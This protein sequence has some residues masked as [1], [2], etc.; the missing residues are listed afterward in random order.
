[1]TSAP[2]P[3]T[4]ASDL[5]GLLKRCAELCSSAEP[6]VERLP[7]ERQ[8]FLGGSLSDT[9]QQL[10]VLLR[11]I[12]EESREAGKKEEKGGFLRRL[13]HRS[14]GETGEKKPNELP[15]FDVSQQGLLG[16]SWTVSLS[17]LIAFLGHGRKSGVLWVDSPDENFLIGMANGQV[18]HASSSRTPEGLRLGEILVGR[19]YLTRRQLDRFLT[20]R[21]LDGGNVS[22]EAFL[23]SGM[24]TGDELRAALTQQ[25]QQLFYRFVHAKNAVFRFRE[26]L[27]VALQHQ[28]CLNVNQLL[29]DSARHQDES[30]NPT[31]RDAALTQAW[32]SFQ[33]DLSSEYVAEDGEAPAQEASAESSESTETA[34]SEPG[35]KL[36]ASE[37]EEPGG[38]LPSEVQAE[39]EVDA[40]TS[41]EAD[42][43]DTADVEAEADDDDTVELGSGDDERR[44]RRDRKRRDRR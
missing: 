12:D 1:M 27:Q 5:P 35:E 29:L 17:E 44:S 25:V 16:N 13:F 28:V 20:S 3:Q 31:L 10:Q 22:G 43:E 41:V 11:V 4:G 24:I 36:S 15:T 8:S 26:G 39:V 42:S 30:S 21:N 2:R 18:M 23:E 14:E 32:S 33:S 9:L 19:G 37:D 6:L 7:S 38:P 40:E 34:E